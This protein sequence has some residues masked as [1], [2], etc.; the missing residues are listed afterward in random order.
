MRVRMKTQIGGYRD[1]Q[2]WP[3]PGGT[4]DVPDPEGRDLIAAG[5]AEATEPESAAAA[6]ADEAD[7]TTKSHRELVALAKAAGLKANG[8]ADALRERLAA[9]LQEQADAD[10]DE[11][12]PAGDDA[13]PAAEDG[14]DAAAA[15]H[16]DAA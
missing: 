15:S 9:H 1:L 14:D 11:S 16:D 5:Y 12:D 4:I 6:P 2:P 10:H 7:L 8:S 13:S 3:A